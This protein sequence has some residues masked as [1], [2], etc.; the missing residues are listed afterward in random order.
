MSATIP[1]HFYGDWPELEL[2]E[3]GRR[4]AYAYDDTNELL[5]RL[6]N[7]NGGT[8]DTRHNWWRGGY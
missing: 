6:V 5:H 7:A 8:Y 2:I 3:I 4:A 1:R